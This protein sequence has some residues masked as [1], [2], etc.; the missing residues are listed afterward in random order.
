MIAKPS[1]PVKRTRI[2]DN[3]WDR[4][5]LVSKLYASW[6][7]VRRVVLAFLPV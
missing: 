5:V 6:A 4:L 7:F 2:E 1:Y 3:R